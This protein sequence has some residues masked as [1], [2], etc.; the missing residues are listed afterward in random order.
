MFSTAG[1]VIRSVTDLGGRNFARSAHLATQSIDSP[2]IAFR[3]LQ[4]RG[5]LFYSG[6]IYF[7]FLGCSLR[8]VYVEFSFYSLL[9]GQLRL[10]VVHP[11]FRTMASSSI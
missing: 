8:R 1:P 6:P 10:A 5:A 3:Q 2:G 4:H 9:I 7:L 11:F